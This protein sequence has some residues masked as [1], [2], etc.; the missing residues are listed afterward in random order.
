[1]ATTTTA[2][3]ATLRRRSTM[4][5]PC[6]GRCDGIGAAAAEIRVVGDRSDL[7]QH[8][9]AALALL[10]GGK[11]NARGD[12]RRVRRAERIRR[13]VARL[14]ARRRGDAD[15]RQID[16]GKIDSRGIHLTVEV[17]RRLGL[18]A[19]AD[20]LLRALELDGAG[21]DAAQ[22]PDLLPFRRQGGIA[23]A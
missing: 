23:P 10:A 7:R 12:A 6:G 20:A 18:Q 5:R 13:N 2:A 17:D 22:R 8:L 21:D 16:A 15:F 4:R 1:M 19:G 14:E 11:A 3:T 9:P